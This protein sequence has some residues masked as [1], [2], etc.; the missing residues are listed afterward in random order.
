V[1][2]DPNSLRVVSRGVDP[3]TEQVSDLYEIEIIRKHEDFI[4]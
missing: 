2:A 3:M 1:H 4:I